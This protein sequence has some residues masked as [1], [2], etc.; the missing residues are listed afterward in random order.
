M[1]NY[2][3]ALSATSNNQMLGGLFSGI[4]IFSGILCLIFIISYWKIF[5]KAGKPGWA[6]IVPIYNIVVMLEIAGMSPLFILLFLIPFVNIIVLFMVNIKIANKFGKSSS[7]G[8]GMTLLSIIFVPI[9]AFSDNKIENNVE[10]NVSPNEFDA[11]NVINNGEQPLNNAETQMNGAPVINI[12]TQNINTME[13][14]DTQSNLATE[15]TSGTDSVEPSV[16]DN[17]PENV[18]PEPVQDAPV[19]NEEP[20]AFN[21]APEAVNPEPVQ[22][23]P[24]VNEEPSAFNQ[25]PEAVN[26]EPVQDAPNVTEPVINEAPVADISI[27]NSTTT[28]S[29]KKICKNCGKE[30]PT[31]VSICPE[32]G[33]E[34]E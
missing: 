8:I 25:V 16:I 24:V 31:I 26:P 9:L 19:V 21:Q 10:K 14:T 15:T 28:E 33:T 4:L 18:N 34:N 12:E 30:M 29:D 6:S 7:F 22:D 5:T 32:C 17:I 1:F 27:D 13:N 3:D 20:S 11:M 23:A 2:N